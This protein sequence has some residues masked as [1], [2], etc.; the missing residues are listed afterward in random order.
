MRIGPFLSI[1]LAASLA[2]A[3]CGSDKGEKGKGGTTAAKQA[4]TGPPE[5][6]KVPTP[7]PKPEP[8]LAQPSLRLDPGKT[9]NA[10]VETNCGSFT[11]TLDVKNSPKTAA[12][13]VYLARQRFYDGL[14]FHRVIRGFVIQGGDP[15]GNGTGGPG[16]QV[17]EAPPRSVRYTRGVVAMAKTEA[18]DP[19]TSGSQ[20]YVVTGEDAQL[21]PD[22]AVLGR[23]TAGQDVVGAIEIVP[24]DQRSSDPGRLDRPLSPVVIRRIS[25]QES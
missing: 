9:Y 12:S 16:Y 25:I 13:F 8:N 5:C 14:T 21:P 6:E 18:E 24:T 2:L 1:A 10:V 17:V 19:G 23:V 3:G 11:I 15:R 7:R 20:F 22:Y 4:T